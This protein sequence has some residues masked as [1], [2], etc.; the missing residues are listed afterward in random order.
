MTKDQLISRIDRL[1]MIQDV[2]DG[3]DKEASL[4]GRELFSGTMNII[5]N[6]YGPASPQ[7]D[8]LLE[9]NQRTMHLNYNEGYKNRYLIQELKGTL[10][11]IK[12][13]I[14]HG[15]L[16]SIRKQAKA[17]IL[18]DFIYLAKHSLDENNKD[19]AAVLSCAALEDTLKKYADDN[20]L[21]VEDKDMSEVIGTLKSKG[22][23]QA[24][25]AKVLSSFVTIRNKAFHAEWNK[26]DSSEVHSV[27]GF[28]QDFIIQKF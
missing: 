8:A 13:E 3:Q 25:Q 10:K 20:G 16:D 19:V 23:L 22:L 17:E 15:L 27:I 28:V 9:I 6:I 5:S 2:K 7:I 12:E 18:S 24:P 1:L 14:E 21:D 26:I 11:T 4:K